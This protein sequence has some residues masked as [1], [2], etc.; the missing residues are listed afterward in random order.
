MSICMSIAMSI[1]MSVRRAISIIL[2]LFVRIRERRGNL[3]AC[4]INGCFSS[5]VAP[6][7]AAPSTFRVR[8]DVEGDEEEQVGAEN[9]A[10]SDRSELLSCALTMIGHPGPVGGGKIGVRGIV[11]KTKID[12]KLND[13]ENGDIFL[14]PDLNASRGLEIVPVHDHMHSQIESDRDP[15]NWGKPDQLCIAKQCRGTMVIRVKESQRLFL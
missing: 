4:H 11:D 6:L 5:S 1:G 8:G 15:R 2:R 10:T 3:E 7:S 9:D 12:H 14:P 13:L